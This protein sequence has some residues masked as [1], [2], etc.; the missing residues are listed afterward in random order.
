MRVNKMKLFI[1]LLPIFL[2]INCGGQSQIK[3]YNITDKDTVY[4]IVLK[5]KSIPGDLGISTIASL[6]EPLRGL[7]AF[8][9][10]MGGTM[11]DGESCELTTALGLGKQGSDKHKALIEKY[12]PSDKVAIMVLKQDCYL[13]PSSASSFSD[14]E[15]LRIIDK[16][17]TVIVD[18]NLMNYNYG[19]I[20]W[21]KG[22]DI[23]SFKDNEFKKIKRNLWTQ[24]E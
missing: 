16:G 6:S 21:T 5:S 9:A 19:E 3:E 17:D 11:C 23:Y 18:Y 4:N 1:A 22:P 15:F 13:R 24:V 7:A 8:Y 20:K 12:F 14:Y 2:F 10:A